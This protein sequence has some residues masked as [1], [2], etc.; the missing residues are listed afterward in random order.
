M[1]KELQFGV[2]DATNVEDNVFSSPE[3]MYSNKSVSN[4]AG[5]VDVARAIANNTVPS[6]VGKYSVY[7][8]DKIMNSFSD[9]PDNIDDTFQP[10]NV[11]K[12]GGHSEQEFDTIMDM[13]NW[14]QYNNYQTFRE[15]TDKQKQVIAE[16][17]ITGQAASIITNLATDPTTYFGFG[18]SKMLNAGIS[19]VG[20]FAV[21]G[22]AG[23]LSSEGLEQLTDPERTALDSV[24]SIAVSAALGGVLGQASETL[25]YLINAKRVKA[26]SFSDFGEKV[27][28]DAI[29]LDEIGK[30]KSIGADY[31]RKVADNRIGGSTVGR[32]SANALNKINISAKVRGQVAESQFTSDIYG[33]LFGLNARSVDNFNG[34]RTSESV[35]EI[36]ELEKSSAS[37]YIKFE[38]ELSTKYKK[39]G[40]IPN[41]ENY[42]KAALISRFSKE[43]IQKALSEGNLHP[44]EAELATKYKEYFDDNWRPKLEQ[45]EGFQSLNLYGIQNRIDADRVSQNFDEY[46]NFIERNIRSQKLQSTNVI[47]NSRKMLSK[48]QQQLTSATGASAKSLERKIDD[49]Q[50]QINKMEDISEMSDDTI[51]QEAIRT[52]NEHAQGTFNTLD[53]IS[54]KTK[55][56]AFNHRN[57]SMEDMIKFIHV[58]PAGVFG[59]Y[60]QDVAPF[61]ALN[62]VFGSIELDDIVSDYSQSIDKQI[63]AARQAQDIKLVEKLNNEK[64]SA[65]SDIKIGFEQI[66]G[67]FFAKEVNRGKTLNTASIATSQAVRAVNL[68]NQV[69]GSLSELTAGTVHHGLKFAAPQLRNMLNTFFNKQYRGKVMESANR[70]G[71][72]LEVVKNKQLIGAV[73]AEVNAIS[74]YGKAVKKASEFTSRFSKWNGSVFY[75]SWSRSTMLHTQEGLISDYIKAYANGKDIGKHLVSDLAYLG[76]DKSNVNRIST[77]LSKYADDVDGQLF[78][79]SDKWSDKDAALAWDLALRRDLM[80]T[81]IQPSIGDTP[82]FFRTNEGRIISA[83][84]SWPVAATQK[85]LL[86]SLQRSD[87]AAMTGIATFVGFSSL[88]NAFYDFSTGKEVSTDA[89][90]LLWGGITRSG[91]VGVLPDLGGNLIANKFFDIQSGGAKYAD[92]Q[93]AGDFVLGP[94]GSLLS[95]VSNVATPLNNG[96]FQ[97]NAA[98]SAVDLLPIPTPFVKPMLRKQVEEAVK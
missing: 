75:D 10:F 33:K 51:R 79:N 74:M 11:W 68:S 63:V 84:K 30:T 3:P 38:Q 26:D 16:S 72:G 50:V 39:E 62:K 78:A 45:V 47:E 31:V 25:G 8:A 2:S 28:Q 96:K 37:N 18:V 92:F 55:P 7:Y 14:D 81:S 4:D 66:T 95:D 5:I 22:A 73:D 57:A 94:F 6:K 58:D 42:E 65:I 15:D 82:F 36:A 85:Y 21:A 40:F 35:E 87:M 48:L 97:P 76:I 64:A 44:Y 34:I 41:R 32:I 1:T 67:E 12:E 77:M 71:V 98:T 9:N 17:G 23:G 53:S 43:E 69:A 61:Y 54:G 90:E 88:A 46:V 60:A 52:A 83:F 24:K 93:E 86:M 20:S 27:M 91:I 13:Q 89:D 80:R 19:R 70:I 56:R 49:I 59:G 29:K